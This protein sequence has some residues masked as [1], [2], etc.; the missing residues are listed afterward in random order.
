MKSKT[1]L[2]R[3]RVYAATYCYYRYHTLVSASEVG[4]ERSGVL[5]HR[6]LLQIGNET[7][8]GEYAPGYPTRVVMS[9]THAM[10][11]AYGTTAAARRASRVELWNKL[12]QLTLGLV[13][14]VVEGQTL[15]VCATSPAAVRRWLSG[16]TLAAV[17]DGWKSHPRIHAAPIAQFT[18][19]WPAGQ[20][21]PTAYVGLQSGSIDQGTSP[22]GRPGASAS[23]PVAAG[24]GENGLC[25]RLRL[26]YSKARIEE[27]RVNGQPVARSESDGFVDWS[28]RGCRYVQINLPPTRLKTDDL[29]VVTCRYDPGEKR[30]HWDTWRRVG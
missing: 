23:T 27:L 13:D 18:A 3:P 8:P 28:A 11:T 6:R 17:V 22:I 24:P 26:P 1:W 16:R 7:W 12:P 20:N 14:P 29:F 19:G 9:N 15:C 21:A 10:L 30:G 4:W 5:R 2:G 25:L